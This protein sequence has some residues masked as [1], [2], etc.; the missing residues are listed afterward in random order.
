MPLLTKNEPIMSNPVQKNTERFEELA[1]AFSSEESTP[2]VNFSDTEIAF[3]YKNNTELKKM[4]WLFGLM[5]KHWLVGL[6][7][8]VGIAAIRM[9]LP[10]VQSMVR[11]T[12]F[13]QFC[14]GTTLLEAEATIDKIN[15]FGVSTVLDFGAEGKESEA[16]F[17]KTMNETIRAIQFASDKD[18][19]PMVS[20]KVTGLARFGLLE[21]IQKGEPTTDDIR[22]EYKNVLKRMDAICHT[23]SQNNTAVMFDAEETWIQDTIDHMVT[24]M[25]RRYNR[26]KVVVYNTAQL[27]RTDRL[28]YIMDAYDQARKAGYMLGMKLVRGAYMDKERAR[29][30]ELG[31]PSPIHPDKKATDDAYN[32][33][34]R[35]CIEHYETM[36]SSNS[37]HNRESNLLQVEMMLEKG[38]PKKHPHLNFCQLYGMSDNI[39]FNLAKHGFFVAKYLPYGQISD[40]V[41]YLIRRAEENSSVAGDMSREYGMVHTEVKRRGIEG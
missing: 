38:I 24:V 20:S 7:A 37:S 22:N 30:A 18:A 28:Q 35:F 41:P 10:F 14:G 33:A 9:R 26:E 39:T 16:D 19:V 32:T 12:I 23:A 8:K 1:T 11:H 27:Y 29:A 25:M 13:E 21:Y 2:K 34:M 3:A 40:V 4:L 15:K 31:Y 36:A 6:G 5:N 17:N